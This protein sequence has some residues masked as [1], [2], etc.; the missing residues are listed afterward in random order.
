MATPTDHPTCTA[1]VLAG[2]RP[3]TDPLAAHF[4]VALKALVPVRGQPMLVRVVET[5]RAHAFVDKIVVVSQDH[6]SFRDL[7][8]LNHDDRLSFFAGGDSVS[9]ALADAM[10]AVATDYPFLVTTADNVLID[11]DIITRFVERAT[12]DGAD[13]AVAV[14]E[15]RVLETAYPGNR[16]TWLRF[17]GG[18]YS[19][20]NLFWFADP[21][22]LRVLSTWRGIEQQR[23]RGRA[24]V[25]A[26]GPLILAA[27]GMRLASLDQALRWAGRRLGVRTAAVVLPVAE[28]CIDVDSVADHALVEAIVAGRA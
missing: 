2:R 6:D 16:R 25:G 19:G 24:V 5:L 15:R 27:V 20:A 8:A 17:R 18:A 28:A 23:K 3:G 22:G 21:R 7:P 11:A 4:D 13:L 12:A 26:F 9:E 10:G 14:V 1:I